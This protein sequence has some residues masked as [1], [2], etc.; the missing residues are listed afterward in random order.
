[1]TRLGVWGV[2][3]VLIVLLPLVLQGVNGTFLDPSEEV[4]GGQTTVALAF[5]RAVSERGELFL[6]ACALTGAIIG[7]MYNIQDH[8]LHRLR[9]VVGVA[10][11]LVFTVC[12]FC[13]PLAPK[14]ALQIPWF[15]VQWLAVSI[16]VSGAGIILTSIDRERHV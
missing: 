1:L 7:E 14:L 5:V 3:S 6:L 4:R 10:S 11:L 12:A 8:K 2:S 15:G 16:F 9:T 13:F